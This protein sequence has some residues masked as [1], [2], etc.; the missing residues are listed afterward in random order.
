M[1]V[2]WECDFATLNVKLELEHSM[3][4]KVAKR[5]VAP[6]RNKLK[7]SCLHQKWKSLKDQ[8]RKGQRKFHKLV[9]AFSFGSYLCNSETT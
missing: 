4:K 2:N 3:K 6:P 8:H 5:L 9:C 1:E 7:L